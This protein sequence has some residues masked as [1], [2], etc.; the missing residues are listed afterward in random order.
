MLHVTENMMLVPIYLAT[1]NISHNAP[2]L[3]V[4][5][6]FRFVKRNLHTKSMTIKSNKSLSKK[7][8]FFW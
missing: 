4:L 5:W 7:S 8:L 1:Q 6:Y 3:N 2:A